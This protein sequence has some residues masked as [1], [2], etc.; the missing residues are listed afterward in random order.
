MDSG[1]FESASRVCTFTFCLCTLYLTYILKPYA[2]HQ[3][4][5]SLFIPLRLA[6]DARGLELVTD[7]DP[8]IDNVCNIPPLVLKVTDT[9][10]K[11]ARRAAYEAMGESADTISKHIKAYSQIDGV[12]T[13]DETRLRQIITN[14][15]RCATSPPSMLTHISMH[16]SATLA[17]SL[18]LVAD[19]QSRRG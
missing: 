2:F 3:V 1:N 18:K 10:M 13:G 19:S 7:L 12:V 4:M 9:S 15:A 11:V 17:S 5:R 8:N 6:T 16:I 14:L